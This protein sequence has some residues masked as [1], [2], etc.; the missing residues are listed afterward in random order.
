MLQ[1]FIGFLFSIFQCKNSTSIVTPFYYEEND[2]NKKIYILHVGVPKL[3]LS[4]QMVF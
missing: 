1:F 4:D 2:L 3:Q